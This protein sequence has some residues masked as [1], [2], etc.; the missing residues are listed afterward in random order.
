MEIERKFLVPS[1]P[2]G[3]DSARSEPIDQG[4]LAIGDEGEEVRLRRLG[5]ESYLTVKRGRG[6]VRT[7][8]EV[9]LDREQF[10]ALWPL[11]E[12][13]R[14][15]K[16]RHWLP[17][18]DLEIELDVYAGELDGLVTAEIEF[19][20]EDDADAFEPPDWLGEDVTDDDRY[21]NESLATDGL[22][23]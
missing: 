10:D 19:E 9:T 2:D 17:L 23:D 8:Q 11:T 5:E 3:L 13:R 22:P 14:I 16:T 18:G 21:K 20:S 12:D 4:Y 6:E 15:S 1:P 7:E